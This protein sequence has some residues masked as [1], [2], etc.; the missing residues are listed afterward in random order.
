MF[1]PAETYTTRGWSIIHSLFDALVD[2]GPDGSVVPL[3]AETFETEDAITFAV[4]L[5]EGMTFHDGSPVTSAARDPCVF[6]FYRTISPW[7]AAF[8]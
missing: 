2:F 8:Q 1:D 6:G 7:S 4:K 5:R 3:A